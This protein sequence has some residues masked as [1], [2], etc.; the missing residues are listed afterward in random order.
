MQLSGATEL[1]VTT[2]HHGFIRPRVDY[3]RLGMQS[4]SDYEGL[5]DNKVKIIRNINA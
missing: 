5:I 1:H 2:A 3:V 4:R